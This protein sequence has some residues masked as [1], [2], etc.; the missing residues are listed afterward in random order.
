LKF[1]GK[2]AYALARQGIRI[3][4]PKRVVRINAIEILSVEI[5]EIT[6][7]IRCAG[8]TYIRSLAADM[9]RALGTGAY[10]KSLRRLSS[11]PFHVRDAV[12][13]ASLQD[14]GLHKDLA[15]HTI[16]LNDALPDMKASQVD[17][18]MSRKIRNG[19]RPS[20]EE[21]VTQ[22]HCIDNHVG[23]VKLVNG[24]T[25]IAIMELRQP[26][27]TGRDWFQKIRVFH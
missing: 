11:G 21:I 13:S 6:I 14:L 5:P 16:S 12:A 20:M 2:R 27:N 1:K 25:L 10:L 22:S 17:D 3:V 9:G 24:T 4:L 7:K 15:V 18:P 23:P 26:D 8:G 19:Y